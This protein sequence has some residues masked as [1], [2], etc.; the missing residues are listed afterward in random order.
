MTSVPLEVLDHGDLLRFSFDD[1][2]KYSGRSSIG[3]VAHG[4]KVM[5]RAL[6]LLCEGGA[7]P[8]RVDISIESA[9]GGGGARDAFEMVTRAVTG[10]RFRVDEDLAPDGP[11]SPMG[12]YAFRF[13][14]RAGRVVQLTLRP[15]LVV[16]E[17]VELARRGPESPVEE[18][19][20]AALKQE[21]ADLL[22]SL[23]PDAVYDADRL[24][25]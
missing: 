12:K 7:A 23:P 5:E 17:F 2:V 3:G 19:R 10:G 11:A 22:M 8:D 21:M 20:L 15:G 4:F 6:P 24:Q 14:H 25:S 9:F 16:D 1:L 18:Q 13:S